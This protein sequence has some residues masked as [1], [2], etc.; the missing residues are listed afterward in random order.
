MG[1]KSAANEKKRMAKQR[2]ER[3]Q[4]ETKKRTELLGE[5]VKVL[6]DENVRRQGRPGLVLVF[7]G[8]F[9]DGLGDGR[10]A[11]LVASQLVQDGRRPCQGRRQLGVQ[12]ALGIGRLGLCAKKV[13]SSVPGAITNQCLVRTLKV[14]DNV[15]RQGILILVARQQ[16]AHLVEQQRT[17]LER[18]RHT[19]HNNTDTENGK[20][21]RDSDRSSPDGAR[22]PTKL[23]YPS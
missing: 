3:K 16:W 9:R 14:D 21:D 15:R 12:L 7:L 18:N 17:L 8:R 10:P 4:G 13:T 22:L 5:L 20:V 11:P 2:Q 19:E 23:G 1:I 6:E